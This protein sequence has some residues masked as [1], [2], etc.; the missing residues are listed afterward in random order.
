[1]FLRTLFCIIVLSLYLFCVG[2]HVIFLPYADDKRNVDY[3]EKVPASQE[4]VNKMKEIIQKLRFKYRYMQIN[5]VWGAHR[6]E[7]TTLSL[8]L[9]YV[10]FSCSF[11]TID[12]GVCVH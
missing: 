8:A 6:E 9:L 5:S 1:M 2:F 11:H 12:F 4:Q 3:T 7:R 10:F